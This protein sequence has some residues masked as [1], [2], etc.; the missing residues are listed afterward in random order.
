M[1]PSGIGPATFRFVAQHL[2]HC[3]IAVPSAATGMS[4][5]S[6]QTVSHLYTTQQLK[7]PPTAPHTITAQPT[8]TRLRKTTKTNEHIVPKTIN[9]PGTLPVVTALYHTRR[10]H[11]SVVS[12]WWWAWNCPKHV[13]QFIKRNKILRKVTSG[14]FCYLHRIKKHGQPHIEVFRLSGVGR[15]TDNPLLYNATTCQKP[16]IEGTVWILPRW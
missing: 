4:F 5:I 6:L 8:Y 16:S 11:R 12:S 3:A 2:N 14:W 7:P 1:T 9:I 10:S 15:A 13:E